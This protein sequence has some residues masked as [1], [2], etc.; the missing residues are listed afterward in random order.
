[1]R[2]LL[3]QARREEEKHRSEARVEA[4]VPPS[5]PGV[6][7][8]QSAP[9]VKPL[10]D[11]P[12]LAQTRERIASLRS[13]LTFQNQEIGNRKQEQQRLIS[14]IA[15]YQSR[16]N[17]IPLREQEMAALTRDYEISKGNYRSLQDKKIAAEMAVD[18]ERREK[19]ER[20]TVVDPARVPARPFSPKRLQLNLIG[21]VLGL[22]LGLALGFGK[23][24]KSA[25]LLGEWELPSGVTILGRLPHIEI[26]PNDSDDAGGKSPHNTKKRSLW[27]LAI[28]SS[29]LVSLLGVMAAGLYFVAHRY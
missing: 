6:S 17:G 4:E 19:S 1:M 13:Q 23:E 14:E 10:S 11:S 3:E 21:S 18:M 7:G 15:I 24:L 8:A 5:A 25:T 12:A 2:S 26:T 16:V 27:R 20:F 9:R 22:V 28:V 29:A